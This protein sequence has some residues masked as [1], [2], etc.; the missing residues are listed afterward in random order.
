MHFESTWT[1]EDV[2]QDQSRVTIRMVFESAK[3]M[4]F[5]VR[6]HGAVEGGLQTLAR[7]AEFLPT[8]GGR[9]KA[10]EGYVIE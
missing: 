8:L 10:A 3:D 5:V 7:L 9:S 6:E 2:G 1:F 4:E